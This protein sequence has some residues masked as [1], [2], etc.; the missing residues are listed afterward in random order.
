MVYLFIFL[1]HYKKK[2]KGKKK[3]SVGLE[4]GG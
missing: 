2:K 3:T 1:I 4:K